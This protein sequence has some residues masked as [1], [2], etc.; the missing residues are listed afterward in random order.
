MQGS[1]G[2]WRDTKIRELMLPNN[3][4]IYGEIA[5]IDMKLEGGDDEVISDKRILTIIDCAVFAG[6][7]L[8]DLP[9]ENR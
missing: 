4:V 6:E 8:I 1:T 5:D 7:L 2:S 9:F 3:T